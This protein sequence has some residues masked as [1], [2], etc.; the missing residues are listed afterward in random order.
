MKGE[1]IRVLIVDD[2]QLMI[3]G[4][5]AL[6]QD[7]ENISFVAGATSHQETMAV[8]EQQN[9]D[10]ILMDIN[11]PETS[12]IEITKKVKECY[13]DIKI[14]ALTMHDDI[15]VISKMIRAGASG[16][17]M[18]KT[19][20]HEVI[21]AVR[22]VHRSGKYLSAGAQN[23]IMDNLMSPEELM[24]DKS[25]A[26][27]LLSSR[28]MDVLKLIA[29]ELSNEQIGEKLFISERTVEVHRRNIFIKTGTKSVVGLMKFA[30]QKGLI[31]I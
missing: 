31:S 16:Y 9:I 23:I 18:K 26:K 20:M 22:T 24:D 14:V 28:E 1:N 12:G 17:V 29:T 8:L 5:K 19:N 10:V 11:M 7:E 15:S 6:L 4:L 3:E 30:I 27:P 25:N 21:D 2:H 13:P